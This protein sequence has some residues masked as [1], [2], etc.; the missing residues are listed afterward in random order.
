MKV[1]YS[2]QNVGHLL[3]SKARAIHSTLSHPDFSWRIS[4]TK[5]RGQYEH[6]CN[7]KHVQNL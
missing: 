3:L 5:S 6:G 7:T 1:H 4:I 2:I